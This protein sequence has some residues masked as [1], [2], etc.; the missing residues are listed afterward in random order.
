MN[1]T[2]AEE[3]NTQT[4]SAASNLGATAV[5]E[6]AGRDSPPCPPEIWA[7]HQELPTDQTAS[8]TKLKARNERMLRK[9]VMGTNCLS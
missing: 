2:K 1:S 3:V 7:R 5:A 6:A 4:L 9:R 8:D